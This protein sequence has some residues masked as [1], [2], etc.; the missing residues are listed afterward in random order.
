MNKKSLLS[1]AL[2]GAFSLQALGA[3]APVAPAA[4]P[5]AIAKP[6]DWRENYAYTLGVQAVIYGFPMMKDMLTR[7]GMV[8]KPQG[9]IKGTVNGWWHS[10][11]PGNA[12]DKYNASINDDQLYSVS[13]FDVAKEPLVIT[14]PDAGER[15]YSVQMME[16]NSDIFDYIGIRATGNKAGSYLLVGPDWKGTLPEGIAGLRRSPTPTGMLILRITVDA[17]DKLESAKALQDKTGIAPL[18]N[19]L[20]KAPYIPTVRDVLDPVPAQTGDPF[21]FFKTVNRG[22]TENP[23]PAKDAAFVKMLSTIGVG[24]NMGDDF[25]KLDAATQAGLKRATMD[26]IAV[27]KQSAKANYD[28][29]IVNNWAY[30]HVNWGRT[31]QANDFLTRA[32][33]QS[34]AGMQEHHIEEVVKLR[35]YLDA[36]GKAYNGADGRYVLR[37]EPGQLPKV[38]SFWSVTLYD[39]RYDLVANEINRYSLGTKDMKNMVFGKDG[40]LEIYI[41][42]D[43]PASELLSNWLPAP[44]GSFNLFMR[45]YLPD[46]SLIQQTYIP[47]A[48]QRVTQ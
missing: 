8:E 20:S 29:K 37:F 41:Q 14:V 35:A 19:W 44:K 6:A 17:H 36:N 42:A 30:G 7:Y 22:F 27:V 23:P 4:A 32:G 12:E 33:T 45:A 11:R 25:S 10:P 16:M 5:A 48:V 9:I 46:A 47:P 28:S 13:W 3:D 31:A 15:Y 1:I 34:D 24:P 21:W 26:G 18:S 39:E 40:S 38:K 2:L 43:R